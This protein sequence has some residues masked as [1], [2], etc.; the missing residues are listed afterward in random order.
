MMHEKLSKLLQKPV[1]CALNATA[2]LSAT[3]R[4]KV[5]NTCKKNDHGVLLD[6]TTCATFGHQFSL[7]LYEGAHFDAVKRGLAFAAAG[8]SALVSCREGRQCQL[9]K[10]HPILMAIVGPD[11]SMHSAKF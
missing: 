3:Y 6:N 1:Y 2:C 4:A 8:S 5:L 9:S 7:S 10:H 11:E